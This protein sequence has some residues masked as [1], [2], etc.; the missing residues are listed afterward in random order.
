MF[1][2]TKLHIFFYKSV[3]FITKI[4]TN[5]ILKHTHI[6]IPHA[7]RDTKHTKYPYFQF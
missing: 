5:I 4:K 1:E 7:L 3:Y 6:H 2:L